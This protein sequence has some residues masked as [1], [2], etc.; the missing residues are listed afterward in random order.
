M[1][2]REG[3]AVTGVEPVCVQLLFQHFRK[4]RRY[5][6]MI[7]KEEVIQDLIRTKNNLNKIPTK[8]EYDI[9]G[10]YSSATVKRLFASWSNA[11]LEIFD[12]DV[13]I[14]PVIEKNCLQCSGLTRNPKFCSTTCSNK[15]NNSLING[16]KTGR[17][18]T[19][20]ECSICQ[21]P[22]IPKS[23]RRQRCEKCTKKI[24]SKPIVKCQEK[25]NK[26][27]T[28]QTSLIYTSKGYYIPFE[29]A[30]KIMLLTNDTQKYR[31]IRSHAR[32]IAKENALLDK[33]KI[34]N[35]SVHIEC[36]H[37]IPIES[38]SDNSLISVINH[39]SNLI[40][41]CRNH[42]WEFDNGHLCIPKDN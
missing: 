41:L 3:T 18:T 8:N 42:H 6:A 39:P 16:R 31:R 9:Q 5:T 38:F 17:K 13:S 28:P 36:S 24:L 15:Y 2:F 32:K 1:H 21:E 19:F 35:Y 30:T 4:V 14:H 22:S 37:R 20:V 27:N 40:G 10:Q 23:A 11:I 34:C 33:C 7:T 12:Y 25:I 29:Q 26:T